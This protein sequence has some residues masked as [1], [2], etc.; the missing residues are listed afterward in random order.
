MISVGDLANKIAKHLGKKVKLV[1][2][3]SRV[4]PA[5]SEVERLLANSNKLRKATGWKPRYDLDRGL[6]ETIEFLR[7]HQHLYKADLYNV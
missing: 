7:E 5:K 1:E 6:E 3:K 4:R 2:D